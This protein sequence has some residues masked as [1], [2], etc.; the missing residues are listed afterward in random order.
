MLECLFP[1]LE[2]LYL[3]ENKISEIFNP[4]EGFENLIILD[5]ENNNID[6]WNQI[7]I[8]S[9]LKKFLNMIIK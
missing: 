7:K 9:Q 4:I 1:I 3:C 8:L 5:L 2:E 6:H